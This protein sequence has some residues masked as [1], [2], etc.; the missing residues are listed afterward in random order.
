VR[1]TFACCRTSRPE[2]AGR[3]ERRARQMLP[4][5][6]IDINAAENGVF[7]P[8]TATSANPT[9]AVVHSNLHTHGVEGYYQSVNRALEDA[10][11]YDEVVEI[12]DDIRQTLL[13]GGGRGGF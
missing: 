2:S 12:L 7:L 4:E 10:E 6:G 3:L 8:A 13:A 1:S 9:G 11:S 5:H